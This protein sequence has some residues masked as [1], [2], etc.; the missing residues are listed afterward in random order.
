M[1]IRI[2]KSKAERILKEEASAAKTDAGLTDWPGRIRIL[3]EKCAG[4]NLTFIAA[5]GTALLAKSV[6]AN[7]DVFSLKAGVSETGYSARS[8][9]K[10][11]LAANAP[12]LGIDLGVH[13][14]EPLNN[15][16]FFAEDYISDKLPVKP[17]ARNALFELLDCLKAAKNLNEAQARLALRD[18]LHVRLKDTAD[19][20]VSARYGT[21]ATID[22][23]IDVIES[24][25]A[26]DSEHGKR[27]QAAAIGLLDVMYGP[28][29]VV[30][31]K[32]HDPDARFPGDIGVLTDDPDERRIERAFE[33]RDKPV[34]KGDV[35]HFAVKAIKN[36]T[37]TACMIAIGQG[38]KV[39]ELD[40]ALQWAIDHGLLMRVFFSWRA[41]AAET[42][43]WSGLALPK[44][45][46]IAFR[47]I[48][49]RA[50]E[51]EV[52]SEGMTSWIEAG[53]VDG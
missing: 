16:P 45:I 25:V 15:Q 1:G 11:V 12:L 46:E 21:T 5:V 7:V 44:A 52:S 27:A 8:L 17:A 48:L 13:G 40:E 30:G 39:R 37:P 28:D 36:D 6:D 34:T 24:W 26:Q 18:F 33:V 4:T 10:D 43:F 20:D 2:D 22:T 49:R 23:L 35:A 14:R 53:E 42:L 41:F 9:C 51:L 31:G 32:I 38:Q 3:E 47:S 50:E 29:R 19:W